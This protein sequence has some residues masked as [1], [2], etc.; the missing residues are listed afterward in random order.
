MQ[1]LLFSRYS[2]LQCLF[3]IPEIRLANRVEFQPIIRSRDQQHRYIVNLVKKLIKIINPNCQVDSYRQEIFVEEEWRANKEIMNDLFDNREIYAETAPNIFLRYVI[4]SNKTINF[5]LGTLT[6]YLPAIKAFESV[7]GK[8]EK[9]KTTLCVHAWK[10][11]QYMKD[12]IGLLRC[13]LLR[14][15]YATQL[16]VQYI[17][18]VTSTLFFPLFYLFSKLRQG[19]SMYMPDPKK[20]LLA[21]PVIWGISEAD[22]KI[23][24]GVLKNSDDGYLYGDDAFSPGEILHIFG[25]WKFDIADVTNYQQAMEN[26]GYR[27]TNTKEYKVNIKFIFVL[28]KTQLRIFVGFF[29]AL[30][31]F[32]CNR[33]NVF[34]SLYSFKALVYFFDKHLELNNISYHLDLIK[35]DY[36]PAHV[37]NS[38]VSHEY[39][40]R[41]VGIQHIA[42][43]YDA[44]QLAFINIDT[45]IVYGKIFV[46]LFDNCWDGI[47]LEKTGRESLDYLT[48]LMSDSKIVKELE[49]QFVQLYGKRKYRILVLIPSP[50]R[51]NRESLW[52]EFYEGLNIALKINL[53]F[54]IIFQFRDLEVAKQSADTLR[55]FDIAN[56]S[57]KCIA[58]Q[59]SFTTHELM[60]IS[61]LIIV[62]NASFGINEAIAIDKDVFTFDFMGT[63][64]LYFGKYGQDL[65]LDKAE[66][67]VSVIRGLE[68]EFNE[69]QYNGLA[70]KEELNYY[71]DGENCARIG[72][73]VSSVLNT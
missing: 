50:T 37:I 49:S 53:D 38:I 4:G 52:N 47:N 39:Q 67:I 63:G 57:S 1:K 14:I 48:N 17:F 45:Y 64:K 51:L 35:D 29:L 42:S 22:K 71:T 70:M 13:T 23:K 26:K 36:N 40:V 5:I 25:K 19:F 21:M 68:T 72:K 11:S 7:A 31:S 15:L 8:L 18:Y 66:E 10:I 6:Y 55:I 59:Q 69:F 54:H 60:V 16:T 62:P 33:L 65:I 61:D 3:L 2:I 28:L 46:D 32:K 9:E 41:T 73:I 44:P 27:Y 43:P 20:Y 58:G 24:K 12:S 56:S 30:L 34:L